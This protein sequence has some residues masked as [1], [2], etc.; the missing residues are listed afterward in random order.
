M[1]KQILLQFHHQDIP[2]VLVSREHDS[3][4]IHEQEDLPLIFLATV[5]EIFW[6]P[7]GSPPEVSITG[8]I[9]KVP[10][11]TQELSGAVQTVRVNPDLPMLANAPPFPY[12]QQMALKKAYK[13]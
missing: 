5:E 7:T 4:I 11:L 13:L 1:F 9:T 3:E 8:P 12:D 6:S 10:V 2:F